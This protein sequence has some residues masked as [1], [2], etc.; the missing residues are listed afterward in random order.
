ML[1][2]EYKYGKPV[3][4]PSGE[5][6]TYNE[7]AVDCPFVFWHNH[8]YYMMH[9]GFDGKGYQTALATSYDLI[10]W[11]Q[12]S[13]ILP[14]GTGKRWDSGSIAGMWILKHDNL[15]ERPAL[16]K[17]QGKY[18]MIYHSYPDSGYEAGPAEIGLACTDD[19]SLHD[20]TRLESPVL[21]WKDGEDWESGGLYKG[22]LIESQGR[23]Y[24]FYNAKNSEQ[25]VWNEQIGIAYSDD[26]LHWKRHTENPVIRNSRGTWDS[27]FCAEPYI[28]KYNDVWLMFFYGY[29]GKHAREGV[30]YSKDLYH[31]VKLDSPLITHGKAG[32]IDAMHAHKPSIV[33]ENGVLYHYY[34]AVREQKDSDPAFNY[35]PTAMPGESRKEF[36]CITFAASKEIK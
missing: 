7:K 34:C 5:K 24:L 13:V 31:W 4:M 16:K 8:K 19:E 1:K 28:V 36:R 12:E 27:F 10:H 14:R 6:S 29:D 17:V 20:W 33:Y 15:F 23:Y 2:T 26:M 35:D 11:E 22:S 18:W 9:V 21:S 30:A 32:D 25:W 3:L